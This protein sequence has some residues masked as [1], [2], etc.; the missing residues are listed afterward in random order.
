MSGVISTILSRSIPYVTSAKERRIIY[1]ITTLMELGNLSKKSFPLIQKIAI[2]L[3]ITENDKSIAFAMQLHPIVW[4]GLDFYIRPLS[5]KKIVAYQETCGLAY[6]IVNTQEKWSNYATLETVYEET[7][8]IVKYGMN[9]RYQPQSLAD[10]D[11][12]LD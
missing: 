9:L 6:R 7:R 10:L 4:G 11:R 8:H 5:E 12:R 3:A 2:K 1:L